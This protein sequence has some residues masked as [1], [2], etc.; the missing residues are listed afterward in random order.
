MNNIDNKLNQVIIKDSYTFQK[1]D[2]N[3][4]KHYTK[5]NIVNKN[6]DGLYYYIRDDK[7]DDIIYPIYKHEIYDFW[8]KIIIIKNKISWIVFIPSDYN[9]GAN[10]EINLY[11]SPIIN[12]NLLDGP[13]NHQSW[14]PIWNTNKITGNILVNRLLDIDIKNENKDNY[15]NIEIPKSIHIN[16]MNI[17]NPIE[18]IYQKIDNNIYVN[19]Y[20]KQYIILK[21]NEKKEWQLV[22]IDE[23][24]NKL[25]V[26][27]YISFDH[28]VCINNQIPFYY[29]SLKNI[30]KNSDCIE[31]YD[32]PFLKYIHINGYQVIQ[33]KSTDWIEI[34]NQL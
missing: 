26:I 30:E 32:I 11:K 25:S 9:D 31:Q 33:I 20:Y 13:S 19:M 15:L 18:G 3:Y 29:W 34:Q 14:I 6:L 1:N 5:L 23:N 12:Y 10:I 8:I 22:K 7:I 4:M 2:F 24:L 21:D 16:S 17:K 28:P 27:F